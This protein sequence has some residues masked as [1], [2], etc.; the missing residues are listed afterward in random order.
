M[1]VRRRYVEGLNFEL[2]Y[3]AKASFPTLG[4][5]KVV[6]MGLYPLA[7]NSKPAKQATAPPR[8]CPTSTKSYPR[9]LPQTLIKSLIVSPIIRSAWVQDL[10]K[11]ACTAQSSH[12]SF[13]GP[14]ECPSDGY[15]TYS[16]FL[17]DRSATA[18]ATDKVPLKET[19]TRFGAGGCERATYP[20][21][22]ERRGPVFQVYIYILSM[23]G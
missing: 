5:P 11:P 13:E 16:C 20:H 18:L 1:C 4:S 7:A 10:R 3:R 19:M 8:E 21:E 6:T 17:R 9:S 2:I 23:T 22:S 15:G 14:E 12:F